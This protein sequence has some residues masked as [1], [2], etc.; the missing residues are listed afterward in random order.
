MSVETEKKAFDESTAKITEQQ[1]KNLT[2]I[3]VSPFFIESIYE[4]ILKT[5][6]LN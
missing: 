2:E 4:K 1:E 5:F 6:I 3:F